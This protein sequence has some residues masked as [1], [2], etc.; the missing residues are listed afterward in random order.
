MERTGIKP[1]ADHVSHQETDH[2]IS[3]SATTQAELSTYLSSFDK[4]E[5]FDM[6]TGRLKE[7]KIL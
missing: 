2:A 7:K 5:I 6:P 4:Q 3:A 1:I